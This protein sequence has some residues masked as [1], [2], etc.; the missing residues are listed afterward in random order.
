ME[1][2]DNSPPKLGES[3]YLNKNCWLVKSLGYTPYRRCQYCE[4]KFRNCL[5]LH[6]QVVSAILI[7][8]ILISSF[9]IERKNSEFLIIVV[10][11][12]IIVY[13]YFFNKSTDKLIRANFTERK[14]KELLKNFNKTLQQKVDEQTKNIKALSEMKSEFLKIVNH[15][16]RTP[17]SII[18]GM[19]SMLAEGS[20][21]GEKKEDFIKKVYLSSE[22]LETILDDI[23]LAQSLVGGGEPVKFSPCQVEEIVEKQVEH[24]KAQAEMKGLKIIFA[25]PKQTLPMTLADSEMLERAISRLIDNAILYTEKGEVKVLVSLRKEKGKDFIEI[26]VKDSGI[27]LDEE[28][29]K[30][31]FK[32]FHRG[33]NATSLHPNGSGLGLFIVK[34]LINFHRGKVEAQSQGKDRGSTFTITLPIITE[35]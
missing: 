30:N 14:A 22:R 31:L 10:F 16:L 21:K 8:L 29:K 34:E 20:L 12:L 19:T 5:F 7:T 3:G 17:V 9:L 27:G 11:G 28:D 33:Q 13:G 6:Y 15:Q 23:L 24:L 18:K 4:L 1:K 25:K 35:V 2:S 26:S 32:L